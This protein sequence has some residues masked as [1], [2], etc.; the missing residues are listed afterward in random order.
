M[1]EERPKCPDGLGSS[2]QNVLDDPAGGRLALGFL[3]LGWFGC[4]R[5]RLFDDDGFGAGDG[6]DDGGLWEGAVDVWIVL[7]DG[8]RGVLR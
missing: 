5:C 4:A 6:G 1:I 3:V 2:A 8:G 7:W